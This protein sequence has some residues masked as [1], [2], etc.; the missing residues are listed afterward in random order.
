MV[1]YSEPSTTDALY[2]DEDM[3][4]VAQLTA[5]SSPV[6]PA[7]APVHFPSP[8]ATAVPEPSSQEIN[9]LEEKVQKL[10]K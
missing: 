6:E 10:G 5:R 4:L 8:L 1:L 7:K 2:L 9:P 3:D